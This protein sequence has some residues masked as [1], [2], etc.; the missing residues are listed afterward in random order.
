MRTAAAP[1][2][3]PGTGAAPLHES[4]FRARRTGCSRAKITSGL[5][6]ISGSSARLWFCRRPR[7]VSS[8]VFSGVSSASL[9]LAA[10][11]STLPDSTKRRCASLYCRLRCGCPLAFVLRCALLRFFVFGHAVLLDFILCAS[12]RGAGAAPL[13]TVA[14]ID[15]WGGCEVLRFWSWPN[16]PAG[17]RPCQPCL[18]L[19]V[20]EEDAIFARFIRQEHRAKGIDG[21]TANTLRGRRRLR[22]HDGGLSR[23]TG[24]VFLDWLAPSPGLR[25]VDIGCG[26]GAFSELLV[27]RCMPTEV[28]GVDP[29]EGQLAFAQTRPA[30]RL[31]QFRQGDA[32]GA[33]LPERQLRCGR[34]GFG[35]SSSFP[36]P[37]KG[38]R[39]WC[40]L[41]PRGHGRDL[42]LGCRRRRTSYAS[43]STPK[44]VGWASP[45]RCRRVSRRREWKPCGSCGPAL[46]SRRSRR[47]DY[48]AAEFR[49]FR[50]FL[51]DHRDVRERRS[52]DGRGMAA[53]DVARLKERVRER[54]PGGPAGRITYGA[55]ANAIKGRKPG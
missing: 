30:A 13:R 55:R 17:D 40:G 21:R 5:A 23:T 42:C 24:G 51:D 48:G 19:P 52:R 32:D 46:A 12:E 39:R 35:D 34:D 9:G 8:R 26:S 29:S 37:P 11:S 31:A 44:C 25:W 3:F 50:R 45:C 2:R 43:R 10:F 7:R 28:Q 54:L 38:L 1:S 27:E 22:A 18:S 53:G 41:S 47:G 20:A 36:N 4:C 33:A 6:V 16:A 49:R 15:R 14:Q